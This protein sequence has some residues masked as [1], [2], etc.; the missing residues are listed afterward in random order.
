MPFTHSMPELSH[1]CL[2]STD[3]SINPFHQVMCLV[4]AP[5]M[6]CQAFFNLYLHNGCMARDAPA[7]L[8]HP[9]NKR[10]PSTSLSQ[11]HKTHAAKGALCVCQNSWPK[12]TKSAWELYGPYVMN[13]SH[14]GGP[15]WCSPPPG[16]RLLMLHLLLHNRSL[17]AT[18]CS[19]QHSS[20]ALNIS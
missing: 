12:L 4:R 8:P 10:I 5:C 7:I 20:S 17:I 3:C 15:C 14:T 19:S 11:S 13:P 1:I 6:I 9:Q 16:H 18:I 2:H